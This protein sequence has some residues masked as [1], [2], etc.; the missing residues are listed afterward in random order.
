M[1]YLSV[2]IGGAIGAML[3]FGVGNVVDKPSSGFPLAT[4]IVNVLGA[5]CIGLIAAIAVKYGADNSN[6][7]LFFKTGICGGFTTFSAF[8]LESVGLLSAGKWPLAL[9]YMC[10][11]LIVC[12]IAIVLAQSLVK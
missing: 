1:E 12:V 8:S 3:R 4:F 11:S 6:I 7:V 10:L 2:G 9:T 5:F